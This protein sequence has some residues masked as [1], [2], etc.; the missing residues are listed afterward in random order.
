MPSPSVVNPVLPIQTNPHSDFLHY[1][2][3]IIYFLICAGLI[4]LVLLQ[5]TKSEGLTGTLGGASQSV[6]KTKKGWEE[7]L[8]QITLIFASAFIIFSILIAFFAF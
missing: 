4:A 5:T 3:L 8:N 2:L 1:F 7:Q 6:F